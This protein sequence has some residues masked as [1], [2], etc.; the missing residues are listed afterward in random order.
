MSLISRTNTFT[1]HV[2]NQ[3]P[4]TKEVGLY[5][6]T[7]AFQMI[8]M[9][10]PIN[11]DHGQTIELPAPYFETGMRLSAHTEKGTDWQWN[12]QA[13]FE[14]GYSSWNGLEGTAYDLSVMKGSDKDIGI[15]VTPFNHQCEAKVCFPGSC[16]LKEGWTAPDQVY[17]G[18]PADTVCYKGKT[19]FLVVFCP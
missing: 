15:A 17:R 13:L 12:P 14:F 3:C 9:S 6:I 8:Q 11:L 1:L 2:R 10:K 19:D 4:W 16:A 18:S 7:P 5:K